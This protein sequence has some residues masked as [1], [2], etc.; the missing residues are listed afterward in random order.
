MNSL[1]DIG[2]DEGSVS[3]WLDSW[4]KLNIL[5]LFVFLEKV[6]TV[7]DASVVASRLP[8]RSGTEHEDGLATTSLHFLSANIHLQTGHMP[9]EKLELWI[10]L[11]TGPAV[12]AVVGI[13]TPRYCLFRDTVNMASRKESGSLRQ[14]RTSNFLVESK[15]DFTIPL[16]KFTEEEAEVPKSL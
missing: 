3:G 8:I 2:R 11:H 5:S 10:G 6:E 7:G 9:E 1:L 14:R 16:P 12:A 15:K 13:T 4:Q